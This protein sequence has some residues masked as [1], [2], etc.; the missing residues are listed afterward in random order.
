MQLHL[1]NFKLTIMNFQ[2]MSKQRKFLLVSSAVGFISMFLPWVSISMFGYTQS[3][4]GMHKEGILV[5]IC[6]VV[7]GIIAF[8][9]DEKKNLDKT[10][11]TLTLLAG[12]IALLFTIWYYLEITNSLIGSALVGFGIYIAAIAA[13][14]ILVSAYLLR[15]PSDNLKDGFD[16]LKDGLK[17]KFAN[18]PNPPANSD[19]TPKVSETPN[20]NKSGN[21]NPG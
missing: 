2:G 8:V 16:S 18:S 12:V 11:W 6:F 9:D 15:S 7:T 10:M 13:I 3:V 4:N 5:F 1:L 21:E 20:A 14:G 17:S 19:E